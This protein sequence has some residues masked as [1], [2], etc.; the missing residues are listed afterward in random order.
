VFNT[1][2]SLLKL[3][4]EPTIEGVYN[5]IQNSAED[6]ESNRPTIKKISRDSRRIK[7]TDI[8]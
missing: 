2:L 1:E 4:E 8:N 6:A 7:R 5:N 3:F